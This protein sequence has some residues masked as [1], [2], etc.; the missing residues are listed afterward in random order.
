MEKNYSVFCVKRWKTYAVYSH[1]LL[2]TVRA[3]TSYGLKQIVT[4]DAA[5]QGVLDSA[6]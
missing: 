4:E 6:Q 5:V 3:V 2:L 1:V